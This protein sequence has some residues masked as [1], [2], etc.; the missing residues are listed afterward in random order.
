MFEN[1]AR[2]IK[3]ITLLTYTFGPLEIWVPS[4]KRIKIYDAYIY[5]FFRLTRCNMAMKFDLPITGQ[6][7][8]LEFYWSFE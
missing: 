6:K 1:S 8:I 3:Y 5:G 7:V 2:F 4:W